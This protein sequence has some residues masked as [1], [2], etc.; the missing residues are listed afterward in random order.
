MTAPERSSVLQWRVDSEE[1][2]E[3]LH[4][5]L[6]GKLLYRI[7]EGHWGADVALFVMPDRLAIADPLMEQMC[8]TLAEA[9]DAA[10]GE[11][12]AESAAQVLATHILTRHGGLSNGALDGSRTRRLDDRRLRRA[13][14]YMRAHFAE[15]L[16]LETLAGEA[17]MS[18][19][20][21]VRLFKNATGL[22]PHA[23]LVRLR[24]QQARSRLAAGEDRIGEV[25]A[26]CGYESPAHFAAA[27]RRHVGVPPRVYR[28][29]CRST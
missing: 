6:P 22:T 16:T 11:L 1:P 20:H 18:R 23:F 3:S 29:I 2:M 13:V 21:F 4:V 24:M 14:D 28:T 26:A 19:F 25:A 10:W 7:V 12:Y 17:A 9:M 27:F 5:H 8:R 15:A